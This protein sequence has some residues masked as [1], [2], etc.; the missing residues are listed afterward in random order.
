MVVSS[1]SIGGRLTIGTLKTG[2]LL[3]TMFTVTSPTA[4][5]C[6]GR[7]PASAARTLT[8]ATGWR[9]THTHHYTNV[10]RP[11]SVTVKS[12][13]STS[14]CLNLKKG[15]SETYIFIFFIASTNKTQLKNIYCM[16]KKK[17]QSL[18]WKKWSS[19]ISVQYTPL[20]TMNSTGSSDFLHYAHGIQCCSIHKN[21]TLPSTFN[22][23]RLSQVTHVPLAYQDGAGSR[24]SLQTV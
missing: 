7:D 23:D 22:I 8:C 4:I 13:N 19:T 3:R 1:T 21:K 16:H 10:N 5:P 17:K 14:K 15:E 9:H 6:L 18:L 2:G 12:G 11:F 20:W 24:Q